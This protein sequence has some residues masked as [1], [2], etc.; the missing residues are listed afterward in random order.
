MLVRR[1]AERLVGSLVKSERLILEP[2]GLEEVVG[3]LEEAL[4]RA[5]PEAGLVPVVAR[6][7]ETHPKVGEVF[8]TDEELR[9]AMSDLG[10]TWERP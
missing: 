6:A 5:R 7:L 1:F 2:H 4:A 10:F 9:E 8:A 3:A